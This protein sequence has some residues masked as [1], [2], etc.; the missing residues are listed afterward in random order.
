MGAG[1]LLFVRQGPMLRDVTA[2]AERQVRGEKLVEKV[3]EAA[4]EE[5]AA[6]GYGA[7]SIE[8]IAERAGVAKTTLYRRWPTKA[9]LVLAA[10]NRVAGE[11]VAAHDT[12]SLRGDL[13]A[14][15]GTFRD[16]A[17]TPQ[18]GSLMRMMLAEG[19]SGEISKVARTIRES[20]EDSLRAVITRAIKRGE[21]PRGS[22]PKLILDLLFAMVQHYVLFMNDPCDDL[23]IAQFVDL[24]LVGAENGGAR[25]LKRAR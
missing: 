7:T 11:I 3:L 19:A 22:D 13:L 5:L 14:M 4:V 10:L 18:G 25:P 2:H 23:K 16:F 8:D 1:P 6:K 9:D 20:R 24:V 15:L 21:L 17:R 12:G